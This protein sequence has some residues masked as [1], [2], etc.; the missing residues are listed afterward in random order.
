MIQS[1]QITSTE[2]MEALTKDLFVDPVLNDYV[3][4]GFSGDQQ[5][6]DWY[7][8]IGFRPGVTDNATKVARE[9]LELILLNHKSHTTSPPIRGL[10]AFNYGINRSYASGSKD[11]RDQKNGY[12]MRLI[13]SHLRGLVF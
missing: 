5:P 9:N 6:F 8:E 11:T 12:G 4:N 2:Q 10:D 7:V 3:V 13:G 1:D